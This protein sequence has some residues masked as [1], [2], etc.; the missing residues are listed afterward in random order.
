[1]KFTLLTTFLLSLFICTASAQ[2]KPKPERYTLERVYF[3]IVGT[4]SRSG[5]GKIAIYPPN[6]E[7][8][9]RCVSCVERFSFDQELKAQAGQELVAMKIENFVALSDQLVD[10]VVDNG[11]VIIISFSG[12]LRNPNERGL[13]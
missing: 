4:P 2:N 3:E 6:T 12:S 9:G 1:M 7:G 11:K 13:L 5:R 10:V 8:S